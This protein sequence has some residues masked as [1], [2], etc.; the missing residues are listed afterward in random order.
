MSENPLLAQGDENGRTAIMIAAIMF[1]R[2]PISA[3][4]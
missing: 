4:P 3:V 2:D 1:V